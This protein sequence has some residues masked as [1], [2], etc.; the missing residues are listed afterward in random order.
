MHRLRERGESKCIPLAQI[1]F[2]RSAC[3][4]DGMTRP[5]LRESSDLR[6]LLDELLEAWEE[7]GQPNEVSQPKARRNQTVMSFDVARMESVIGLTRHVYETVKAIRLLMDSRMPQSAIPL[8]RLAYECALTAVW[9]VQSEGDEGVRAFAHEY[10]RG[11][12][13]LQKSLREAVSQTFREN[14]GDIAD[15]DPSFFE[16]SIDSV[17]RF[18]VLCNDLEPGGTDAYIYYRLLST[19][20]HAN[21]KVVDLYFDKDPNGGP[22]PAS[23][24]A[25]YEPFGDEVLL[26]L[27]CAA[28]VWSGRTVSYLSDNKEYRRILRNAALQIGVTSEIQLSQAYHQRHA[29][30]KRAARRPQRVKA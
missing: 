15:A 25:P 6:Q 8:I 20:S 22:I 18:D 24:H 27:T 30:K 16:D 2:V 21:I 4:V 5:I 3:Y 12:Q 23:R 13:N 29:T 11:N 14:A 17:R 1:I 10:A 7:Y 28:M 26:F 9:L 19:F